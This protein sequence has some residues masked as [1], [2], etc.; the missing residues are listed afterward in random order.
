MQCR[1]EKLLDAFLNGNETAFEELVRENRD[2]LY[3]AAMRIL[4]NHDDSLD[5]I[6][7]SLV[8][9]YRRAPGFRRESSF[10]TWLV[11]IVVREAINRAKRDRFRDAVSLHTLVRGGP[12]KRV[13]ATL[14]AERIRAAVDSLPPA[15]RAVFAMRQY[16]G[17]KTSE[18]AELTGTSEGTVKA[19]YFN[20]VRKLRLKL[21]PFSQRGERS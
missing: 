15:Q 18:I 20:A 12:D 4:R 14:L 16:E 13:E 8:K 19:N 3:R 9:A 10:S 17:L 2:R 1:E 7:D 5:V 21:S 6:Q 11:S